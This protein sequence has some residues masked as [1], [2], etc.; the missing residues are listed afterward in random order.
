MVKTCKKYSRK[1]RE[2]FSVGDIVK[3][4]GTSTLILWKMDGD[5]FPTVAVGKAERE[6]ILIIIDTKVITNEKN[7][8]QRWKQAVHVLNSTGQTGWVG[9]GWLRRL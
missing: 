9:Q 4:K 6:D 8:S 7:V 5:A 3:S 2:N 1:N